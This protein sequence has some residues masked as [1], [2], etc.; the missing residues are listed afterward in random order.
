MRFFWEKQQRLLRGVSVLGLEGRA[1]HTPEKWRKVLRRGRR[2]A[3]SGTGNLLWQKPPD[4]PVGLDGNAHRR[5]RVSS[6][7]LSAERSWASET[8]FSDL[9][10]LPCGLQFEQE[11]LQGAF[12]PASRHP[13]SSEGTMNNLAIRILTT[14][15]RCDLI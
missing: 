2:Q 11:D 14:R 12:L 1:G 5:R 13:R 9:S 10:F 3:H 15:G 6:A 7:P 8:S 4:L